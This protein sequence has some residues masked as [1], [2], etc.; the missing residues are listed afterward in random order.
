MMWAQHNQNPPPQLKV[1]QQD[2]EGLLWGLIIRRG[3][4]IR[5]PSPFYVWAQGLNRG[6]LLPRMPNEIP[7][8]ARGHGRGR[9][10]AQHLTK[11]LE[12]RGNSVQG[13]DKGES[14]QHS[15][16]ESCIWQAHTPNHALILFPRPPTTL[17]MGWLDRPAPQKVKLTRGHKK[18]NG[19]LV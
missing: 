17:G 4:I 15:T 6:E 10:Y 3:L 8:R 13:Q 11:C 1:G 7:R 5:G 2:F 16:T 9:S 18:G 14:R 12:K 19:T